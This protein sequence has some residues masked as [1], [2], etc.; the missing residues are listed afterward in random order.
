M[1]TSYLKAIFEN[2][3]DNSQMKSDAWCIE[4]TYEAFGI[5]VKVIEANPSSDEITY[6]IKIIDKTTPVEVIK[7]DQDMAVS[8]AS[9]TG[10]V[11][12]SALKN[13]TLVALTLPR[14][15][16]TGHQIPDQY[17]FPSKH[18]NFIQKQ[19]GLWLLRKAKSYY[20]KA[21]KVQ[22]EMDYLIG[23]KRYNDVKQTTN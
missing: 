13:E 11:L 4:L 17:H 14:F 16:T 19:L 7:Y 18:I 3:F 6:I 8:L 15:S 23:L 10:K 2:W 21:M 1:D 5:H 22:K 12:I 9:P 20:Q